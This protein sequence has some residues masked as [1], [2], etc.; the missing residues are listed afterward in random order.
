MR[1]ENGWDGDG[2]G[3]KRC[4]VCDVEFEVRVIDPAASVV[5]LMLGKI[6]RD[7]RAKLFDD[8]LSQSTRFAAYF[9][10]VPRIATIMSLLR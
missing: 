1:R 3:R 8:S 9:N 6:E 4:A 7:Y 5:D 10:T 2:G